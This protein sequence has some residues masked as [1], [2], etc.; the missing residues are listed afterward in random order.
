L[1]YSSNW[2]K[3]LWISVRQHILTEYL[4]LC[5][6]PI[7]QKYGKTRRQRITNI[8]KFV[9]SKDFKDC[10]KRYG[11]QVIQ[12]SDLKNEEKLIKTIEDNKLRE[13][14]L[15]LNKKFKENIKDT[16][17]LAVLTIPRNSKEKEWQMRFCLRHEWIHILL[18]KNKIRFQKIA[19]KYWPYDEGINEY[20]GA[21]LDLKLNKL[22]EF[23]NKENYPLEKKYWVYAIKIRELFKNKNNPKE[24]KRTILDLISKLKK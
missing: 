4:G 17:S 11:G 3:H 16:D 22:E 24:R 1:K 5:P 9:H 2:F 8:S 15:R 6:D 19:K 13:E 21:Y 7:Y 14:L 23:R 20:F 10:L 12:K 18:E